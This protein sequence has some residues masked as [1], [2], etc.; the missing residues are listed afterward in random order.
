MQDTENMKT[1]SIDGKP[2]VTRLHECSDGKHRND[3]QFE[4]Y[5]KRKELF[6]KHPEEF[7]HVDDIVIAAL[8]SEHGIGV[9]IG[10]CNRQDMELASVR[11]SYR[12]FSLFQQMEIQQM[13][14][15]E[16]EKKIVTAPG[17][18]P[19]SGIIV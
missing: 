5:K 2:P 10:K 11:V 13:M 6:E 17:A 16:S 18:K 8:K 9:M 12:I 3:E 15:A 19:T 1:E 4:A 14:K 7:V